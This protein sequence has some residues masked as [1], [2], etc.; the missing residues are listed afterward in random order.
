MGNIIISNKKRIEKHAPYI[1]DIIDFLEHIEKFG[2]KVVFKY[3]KKKQIVEVTY[4]E[5]TDFIRTLS[6][7]FSTVPETLTVSVA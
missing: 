1:I 5:Y 4:K 6:A 3:F 7:G 2:D